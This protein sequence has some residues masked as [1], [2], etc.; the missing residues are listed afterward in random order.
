MFLRLSGHT[1]YVKGFEKFQEWFEDRNIG[2]YNNSLQLERDSHLLQMLPN[3]LVNC[4][5]VVFCDNFEVLN[6]FENLIFY[7]VLSLISEKRR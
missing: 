3:T 5:L 6:S 1:L 4:L 2:S 7:I